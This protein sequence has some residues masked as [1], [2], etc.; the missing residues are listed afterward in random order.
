MINDSFSSTLKKDS[1]EEEL[2]HKSDI[3]NYSHPVPP[4]ENC[5]E[6]HATFNTLKIRVQYHAFGQGLLESLWTVYSKGK[7]QSCLK[8]RNFQNPC[9]KNESKGL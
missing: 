5:D 6:K 9:N 4:S 2:W 3:K 8:F 7:L 1:D